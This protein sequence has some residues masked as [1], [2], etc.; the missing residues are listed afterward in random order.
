MAES[1]EQPPKKKSR[2]ALIWIL[3]VLAALIVC[4]YLLWTNPIFGKKLPQFTGEAITTFTPLPSSTP[5]AGT[6]LPEPTVEMIAPTLAVQVPAENV[7]PVCGQ[8]E[9][10]YILALGIDEVEQ[11]DVIRLV[12]VDFTQRRILILSIPRDFWVPIPGLEDHNI[13]QFRINAAYGYGEYFNGPGQGVV[14]FSETVYQNYGITF[15]RYVVAHF[16]NFSDLVDQIRGVDIYLEEPIGAY[17]SAGH[18]HYDGKS[19]LLFVRQRTADLDAYR[20]QRQSAILKGLYD[21][22]SK[23]EYLLKLPALGI[24]FIQDKSVITDL[25]LQDVSTFTCFIREINRDSLVF[26]DIPYELYTPMV[27]NYGRQ[28]KVPKPEAAIFIQDFLK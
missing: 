16:S 18:H 8:T 14:K 25:R 15:D 24:K 10:M 2:K 5:Q 27:T 17:A 12:R 6:V 11:A 19:A 28:I 13:T 22:L 23:P 4:G 21:K 9:P 3:F 7:K 26:V 1:T 20:I